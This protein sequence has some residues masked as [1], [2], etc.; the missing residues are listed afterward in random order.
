M[1]RNITNE[2]TRVCQILNKNDVQYLIVGGTAVVNSNQ[3]TKKKKQLS[4]MK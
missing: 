2:I 1:Q 3:L 4:S